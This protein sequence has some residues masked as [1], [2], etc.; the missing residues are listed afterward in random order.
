MDQE[1]ILRSATAWQQREKQTSQRLGDAAQNYM[2]SHERAFKKS[3]E[4]VDAWDSLVPEQLQKHSRLS[5]ISGGYIYI[6]VEP[7]AYMHEMQLISAEL[8]ESIRARCPHSGVKKIV[9]API[10]NSIQQET[11]D[12]D[13]S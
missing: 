2:Q 10:R 13:G 4:I 5:K 1:K 7:G 6:E 9:L 8:I 11:N 12:N 3:S